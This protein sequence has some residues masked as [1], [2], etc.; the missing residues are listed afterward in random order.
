MIK[1]EL[2]EEIIFRILLLYQIESTTRNELSKNQLIGK[3]EFSRVI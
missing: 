3:H 2:I 1:K